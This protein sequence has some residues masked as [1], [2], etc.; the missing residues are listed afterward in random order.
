MRDLVPR[1]TPPASG[2]AVTPKV[3]RAEAKPTYKAPP[4]GAMKVKQKGKIFH[5]NT[6]TGKYE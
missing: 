2:L 1:R 5:W 3:E 4:N 6:S